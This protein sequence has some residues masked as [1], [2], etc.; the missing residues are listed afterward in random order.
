TSQP[1]QVWRGRRTWMRAPPV[2]DER[3]V[4]R[5]RRGDERAFAALFERHHRPLL[6]FCRHMLGS[7]DEAE[8]AVQQ[9]FIRAHAALLRGE[10]PERPRAWLYAIARNRCLTL[11]ARRREHPAAEAPEPSTD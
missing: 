8:D 3:L 7:A 1:S 11:L 9:T 10:R 4:A 5:V 2:T 6:S